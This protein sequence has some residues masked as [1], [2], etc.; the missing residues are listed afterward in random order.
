[1]IT[2]RGDAPANLWS[3]LRV[4]LVEQASKDDVAFLITHPICP[5]ANSFVA[6]IDTLLKE[7]PLP[8]I[9]FDTREQL[10]LV[11]GGTK[12]IDRIHYPHAVA[13][14]ILLELESLDSGSVV[15][16]FADL[17]AVFLIGLTEAII[18][19]NRARSTKVARS[20]RYD[21]RLP[22]R[23]CVE[24]ALRDLRETVQDEESCRILD[25]AISVVG[26]FDTD[27]RQH[28]IDRLTTLIGSDISGGNARLWNTLAAR[29]CDW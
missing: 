6:S 8:D 2:T 4:A 20:S 3:R 5:N 9:D 25:A 23:A 29:K 24:S 28:A 17:L 15:V 18:A 11:C 10:M 14:A 1:M 12:H 7:I 21:D 27:L 16:P 22:N 19:E 26:A 13:A